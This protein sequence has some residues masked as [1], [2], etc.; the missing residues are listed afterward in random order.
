MQM[1]N[2]IQWSGWIITIISFFANI[3][4]YFRIKDIN[5]K[6]ENISKNASVLL[7]GIK[8]SLTDSIELIEKSSPPPQA[9]IAI[10]SLKG[11]VKSIVVNI[12]SWL[13][14]YGLNDSAVEQKNG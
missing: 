10:S 2:I 12:R 1:N 9:E 4:Q 5:S 8:D 13:K 7:E 3:I 6:Y 14:N 11:C